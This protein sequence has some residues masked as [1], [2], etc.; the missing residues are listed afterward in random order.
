MK[1]YYYSLNEYLKE[2]YGYKMYKLALNGGMSCPNR[3]GLIDTRGCIFCSAGGSGDFT[4]DSVLKRKN[5]LHVKP[6]FSV[7]EQIEAAKSH[8]QQKYNGGH[9]IAYFQS[10]TNT[11]APVE[12]LRQIFYEAIS[13]KDVDILSIATRPDCINDD[14]LSLLSELNKVKPVWIEL[15]L[16]TIHEK[17]A[18]YIR[19][20]YELSVFD[21]TVRQLK[22]IGISPIV[23]MIIGLPF[24]TR[25]MMLQTTD[26]IAQCGVSGIKLQLLH[27]LKHTDLA[28]DYQAGLFQTMEMS[29]YISCVGEIIQHLPSDMVIHRLTGD[30]PKNLLIAPL[31]S[32]DKKKVMNCMN[33]YF[34]ENNIYQG[35]IYQ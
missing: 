12:Y 20:G 3:D 30:G 11:Y 13:Q 6:L 34:K 29:D 27:V 17:T 4:G 23:H 28:V 2:T 9:Y 7:T 18:E 33:Q 25:E 16:Q 32:A 5:E 35:R 14:V 21:R 1:P 19:R 26:Y 10:Y 31:W 8:I 24:E 15:G 22:S